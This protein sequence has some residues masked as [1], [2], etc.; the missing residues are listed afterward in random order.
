MMTLLIPILLVVFIWALFRTFG[1][2]P[3][4]TIKAGQFNPTPAPVNSA[5]ETW[6]A[7][8]PYPADVRDPMEFRASAPTATTTTTNSQARYEKLVVKGI[9]YSVNNPTAIVG[10]EIVALGDII[11]GVTVVK[12]NVDSVEFELDGQRWTQRVQ[13]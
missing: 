8:E 10:N 11:S 5:K 1:T 2:T 3:T 13:D 9:V 12:I 7:P 4:R 6:K